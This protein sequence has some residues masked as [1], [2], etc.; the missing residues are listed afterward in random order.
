MLKQTYCDTTMDADFWHQKWAGNNIAFH[1][2]QAN[3]LLIKYF[4]TLSLEKGDRI[5][6]PLCGKTLDIA[7]LLSQGYRVAGA[8]LSK[9]AIDQ[10]FAELEIAPNIA[11]HG[12]LIHY[13]AANIDI[14][15][16]DIFDL[17]GEMLGPVDAIY[18]RAAL[19][20]LPREMRDRYTNHL[21][22]ITNKAPQLLICFEYDQTMMAG[23]PHSISHEEVHQHYKNTYALRLAESK[24]M[25]QGLKGK[26]PATKN[27]WVLQTK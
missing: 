17:S 3:S 24:K 1:N 12:E 22:K 14:F 20:A 23:P 10:L 8:E 16:G 6:V 2:S 13:S 5:F 27:V 4:G 21:L 26:C 18:D 15:V 25:P 9:V 11:E 7:W 19:V